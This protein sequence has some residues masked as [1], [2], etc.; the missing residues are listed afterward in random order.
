MSKAWVL[1][2]LLVF[3]ATANAG[4]ADVVD[5]QVQPEGE[6]SYRFS[7]SVRHDDEGW[8]HYADRWEVLDADGNS[9]GVRVLHHPHVNEQPFTRSLSSVRIAEGIDKVTVRARDS[10]HGWGGAEISVA[11]PE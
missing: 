11:V 2:M 7:V 4:K 3:C 6:G 5:V 1:S 8:D 9:L 10:A